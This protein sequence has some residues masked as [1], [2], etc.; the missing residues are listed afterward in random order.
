MTAAPPTQAPNQ[1]PREVALPQP[2]ATDVCPQDATMRPDAEGNCRCP[3]GATCYEDDETAEAQ[4]LAD[5]MAD[6][7][8]A[9]QVKA[10]AEQD[11]EKKPAGC[12]AGATHKVVMS[13]F[14]YH[15]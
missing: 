10:L 9:Q 3:E 5:E 14:K 1:A 12:T 4:E 13:V 8:L 6:P 15:F 2:T 7:A 11:K